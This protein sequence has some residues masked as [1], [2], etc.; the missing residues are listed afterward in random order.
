MA[1]RRGIIM[2]VVVQIH[3]IRCKQFHETNVTTH[4]F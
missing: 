2:I 3:L 4:N 1:H